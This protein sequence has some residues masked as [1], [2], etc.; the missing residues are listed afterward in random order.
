MAATHRKLTAAE[1]A[2]AERYL[3]LEAR[4]ARLGVRLILPFGVGVIGL[5][6]WIAKDSAGAA[7]A[8]WALGAFLLAFPFF[9]ARQV[10]FRIED[11]ARR[12]QGICSSEI[13]PKI[14]KLYLL[15]GSRVSLLPGWDSFWTDGVQVEVDVCHLLKP[16]Q[17]T[18][19]V[20]LLLSLPPVSA[21][22]EAQ[23][24]LANQGNGWL[25]LNAIALALAFIATLWLF[26]ADSEEILGTALNLNAPKHF[27]SVS[28]L[29]RQGEPPT[30]VEIE[31]AKA[32][33]VALD[34]ESYLVELR[35]DDRKDFAPLTLPSSDDSVSFDA[36]AEAQAR[37]NQ[38]LQGLKERVLAKP[39]DSLFEQG[40]EGHLPGS[41]EPVQHLRGIVRKSPTKL[42]FVLG[43]TSD[44]PG[45]WL[46]F[47][48]AVA[49]FG[50]TGVFALRRQRAANRA[51]VEWQRRMV[52]AQPRAE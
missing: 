48:A 19:A 13:V 33:R 24:P 5:G 25:A 44:A 18:P 30:G 49:A 2:L 11:R 16:K 32:Y 31:I 10:R 7:L 34:A 36:Q 12:V 17:N 52:A 26:L 40:G 6:F 20:V 27:A 29:L 15:G 45:V 23:Q 38:A 41:I 4:S 28:E 9:V 35:E 47:L 46:R 50:V 8:F 21:E 22:L 1:R 3:A 43:A 39:H 14:G 51:L 42:T 37:F